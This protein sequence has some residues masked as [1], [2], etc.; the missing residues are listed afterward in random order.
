[1]NARMKE[2][3]SELMG[4]WVPAMH[5]AR[6]GQGDPGWDQRHRGSEGSYAYESVSLHP[7]GF[8][9]DTQKVPTSCFQG[10]FRYRSL[11]LPSESELGSSES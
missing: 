8:L 6:C 3:V 1:M 5:C 4:A 11:L 7:T 9:G 2:C 10:D